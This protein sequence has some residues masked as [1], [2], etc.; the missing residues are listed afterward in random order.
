[1]NAG[2]DDLEF[3]LCQQKETLFCIPLPACKQVVHYH[4]RTSTFAVLPGFSSKAGAGVT[5][6]GGRHIQT[7][8]VGVGI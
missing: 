4:L 3:S 8:A 6:A 7:G 5:N 2:R 1:M